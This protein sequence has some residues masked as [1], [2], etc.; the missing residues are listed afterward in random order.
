MRW[1]S[2]LFTVVIVITVAPVFAQ[3][4]SELKSATGSER[5]G[6]PGKSAVGFDIP[7]FQVSSSKRHRSGYGTLR[8]TSEP[9]PICYTMRTYF[10][11]REDPQ[12]DVTWVVGSSSCQW[13]SKFSLKSAE[14]E[15]K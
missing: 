5:I 11:E 12:S 14:I 3:D 1:F 7:Q 10:V 6:L 13:S 4:S 9:E 2:L 15:L 8:I